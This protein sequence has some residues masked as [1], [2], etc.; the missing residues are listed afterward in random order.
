[1]V[2]LISNISNSIYVSG[3]LSIYRDSCTVLLSTYNGERYIE[4]QIDSILDQK[5]VDIK[6]LIRDD[7]SSDNTLSIID[8]YI[9]K[10]SSR[11]KL[12]Q[13]KNVGIHKSFRELVKQCDV[14]DFICFADQ[15]DIWDNDKIH[16][17][18]SVM[19]S[20]DAHFYS[21]ASRLYSDDSSLLGTT[22]APS[23]YKYYME[24]NSKALTSGC[25]GC[26]MVLSKKFFEFVRERVYPDTYGHDTWITI[27]AYYFTK[28]I[29]DEQCHMSYRQH[30]KSW[31]GNRTKKFRQLFVEFKFY[32]KGLKRYRTIAND[33][34]SY[35]DDILSS[36]D[37]QILKAITGENMTKMQKLKT[38]FKYKTGKYGFFENL[39]YRMYYLFM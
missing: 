10:Y 19:K 9:Q 31:T 37:K 21:S 15:D 26:T 11:I 5:N 6:L 2:E 32:L 28:C 1:M 8:K 25:Q 30:D 35:Y 14:D 38:I 34:L 39:I 36:E 33:L 20:K 23:K 29:Y 27:V 24:S 18:I 7:G 16:F 4:K 3:K 22:A 17:A 13:G 12:L